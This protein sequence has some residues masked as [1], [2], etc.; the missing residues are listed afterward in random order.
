MGMVLIA[1]IFLRGN[2][3]LKNYV[4]YIFLLF[5]AGS[6][7]R[8]AFI[9]I[10]FPVL[11]NIRIN[12]IY[13]FSISI[14]TVF[15]KDQIIS[16]L[17]SYGVGLHQ[18][19]STYI[20]LITHSELSTQFLIFN[21]LFFILILYID[22]KNEKLRNAKQWNLIKWLQF[23]SVLLYSVQGMIP[24]ITRVVLYFTFPQMIYLPNAVERHW[25]PKERRW[26]YFGITMIFIVDFIYNYSK[27]YGEVRPYT[28]IFSK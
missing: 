4:I 2:P 23:T 5:L 16:L 19:Y 1:S 27:G 28:S 12:V 8:S 6:F 15:L 13:L 22:L 25:S 26:M 14:G 17:L 9:A 10:I 11:M 20:G 3:K 24:H 18:R 21:I 7:H